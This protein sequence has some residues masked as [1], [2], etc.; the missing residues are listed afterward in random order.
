ML[1]GTIMLTSR[2][3][4]LLYQE[5]NAEKTGGAIFVV[6]PQM[7]INAHSYY[8][9]CFYHLGYDTESHYAS[10]SLTI[11]PLKVGTMSMV[12]H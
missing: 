10:N 4:N 9:S 8:S 11:R 7:M 2:Q 3:S 5:N 1:V 6:R 12:L